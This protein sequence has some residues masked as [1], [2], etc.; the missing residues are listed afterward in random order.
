MVRVFLCLLI[1]SG[2]YG[3]ELSV[4]VHATGVQKM[5]LLILNQTA[6]ETSK[7]VIATLAHDLAFTQQCDVHVEHGSQALN[8]QYL[9]SRGKEGHSLILVTDVGSTQSTVEWRLYHGLSGAMIAGK[10]VAFEG[11][12][13]RIVAHKVADSVWSSITGNPGFFTT[14]VAY[15]VEKPL[16]DGTYYKHIYT[17]DYDGSNPQPLVTTPTINLA[18]RWN[19]VDKKPLLFYSECTPSNIRLMVVDTHKKKTIV[20]NF[21]GLNMLPTF[22]RDGSKVVYCASKGAGACHL[23]Y[24]DKGA[25][26]KL[27]DNNGNNISP[28]FVDDSNLVFCSDFKTGTPHIYSFCLTTG[29]CEQITTG[30]CSSPAFSP[31]TQKLAY[32]KAVHG[33]HQVFVYDLVTKEHRQVT[34]DDAKKEECSW[35]P[36]GTYIM[37]CVQKGTSSRIAMINTLTS[38]YLYITDQHQ[39]CSYPSWSS[40][41]V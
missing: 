6:D 22:S 39:R 18:P 16:A 37:C 7:N 17:T 35:S 19:L 10:K 41:L 5:P 2:L 31:K 12:C 15:C 33:K 24:Y 23:Y 9:K 40:A 3:Q 25:F 36:C 20:S 29:H 34:H 26:K 21:D 11:E 8:K 28:V 13:D 1:S 30:Y 4:A 38:Q 14:K 27:T 32:C